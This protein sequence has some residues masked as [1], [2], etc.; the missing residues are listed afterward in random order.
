IGH[1]R[2]VRE[3]LEFVELRGQSHTRLRDASGGMQRRLSLATALVHRPELLLLDEPTAS[4][5]PILRERFWKRFAQLRDAGCT[6]L[7]STH[8]VGEAANCDLVAFMA[9][10]HVLAVDTPENLRQRAMGGD[11]IEVT[12]GRLTAEDVADLLADPHV[13][14][15]QRT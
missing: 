11:D 3:V 7:V 5:D 10:G 8:Y 14:A 2:R 13:S 4:V 12:A 1:R 9:D 6:V 15:V